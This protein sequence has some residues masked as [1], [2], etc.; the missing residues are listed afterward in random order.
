MSSC[1]KNLTSQSL[2]Y[3]VFKFINNFITQ[4]NGAV[5]H[6]G[7]WVVKDMHVSFLN[8][9]YTLQIVKSSDLQF[10]FLIMYIYI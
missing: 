3:D 4:L 9:F 6:Y 8:R 5:L 1:D 2:S 7:T 10:I